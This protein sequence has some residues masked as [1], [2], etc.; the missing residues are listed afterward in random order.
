MIRACVRVALWALFLIGHAAMGQALPER[1]PPPPGFTRPEV[2][3]GSFAAYLRNVPLK[4]VGS[5]VLLFDGSRKGRQDAHAAVL[6]ISVGDRELQQCADAVMRLRAEHLFAEQRYAEI[7]FHFTNGFLADF[8][9][10]MNGERIQ[11][12]G[13]TCLWK[14][15]GRT[16]ATR[17]NLLSY[18]NTVFTYAG[19]LSLSKELKV[20]TGPIQ[21][22]DVFIRGGSPGHAVIVLDVARDARERTAFLLAQS[23]MPAQEIHILKRPDGQGAWYVA[24]DG[25]RLVTPEWTFDWS[26][27]MRW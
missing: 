27:R 13:N 3:P 11:V 10:W 23:Y 24:D 17:E 18:L 26:E 7:R 15:E 12:R 5:P 8:Q 25:D 1:L 19:T 16:G 2:A 21:A 9:R 14:G 20:A 4:P 6:D 22:G